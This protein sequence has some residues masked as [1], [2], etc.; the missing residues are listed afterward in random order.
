MTISTTTELTPV[1][2]DDPNARGEINGRPSPVASRPPMRLRSILLASHGGPSAD[3]AVRGADMLARRH[4]AKVEVLYVSEPVLTGIDLPPYAVGIPAS[5]RQLG[6]A[7]TAQLD[8]LLGERPP[9]PMTA[10]IGPIAPTICQIAAERDADLIL[11]GRG[12]HRTL[13]RIMGEE[14]AVHV[15]QAATCPVLAAVPDFDWLPST[16]VVGTDFSRASVRAA[17]VALAVAGSGTRVHLVYVRT[18]L[19]PFPSEP[20]ESDEIYAVGIEALFRA[21]EAEFEA[22]AGLEF[23]HQVL[24]GDP[25][26]QLSRYADRERADLI[27]V[28]SHGRS[29]LKRSILG[30]V[31]TAM[32]RTAH[33]GVLVSGLSRT[34][35]TRKPEVS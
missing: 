31:A 35:Y 1:R 12:R 20:D 18:S 10:A 34:Q 11:L 5:S 21:F 2:T 28:G 24:D 19:D 6:V 13:D 9:W 3:G 26:F 32:I 4:N 23:T 8:Q 22:P 7:I 14:V 15:A 16:I 27:A 29:S 25:A 30:S 33:C 17:R